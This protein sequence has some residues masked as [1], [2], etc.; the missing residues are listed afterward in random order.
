MNLSLIARSS[1]ESTQL[2]KWNIASTLF[3]NKQIWDWLHILDSNPPSGLGLYHRM[4]PTYNVFPR[5]TLCH[6]PSRSW[7]SL[8]KFWSCILWQ[9]NVSREARLSSSEPCPHWARL[10]GL[11]KFGSWKS[12]ASGLRS[13]LTRACGG[14]SQHIGAIFC[15]CS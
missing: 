12:A 13:G 10:G 2:L 9:M 8:K 7:H 3:T 14:G 6:L 4:I 11:A 1:N 5:K 15:G